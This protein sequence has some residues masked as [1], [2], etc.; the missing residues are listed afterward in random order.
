ML[1]DT[2]KY[3]YPMFTSNN[4]CSMNLLPALLEIHAA[5]SSRQPPVNPFTQ[6]WAHT[7]MVVIRAMTILLFLFTID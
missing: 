5:G 6:V 3:S 7:Y 2:K 1:L 4:V